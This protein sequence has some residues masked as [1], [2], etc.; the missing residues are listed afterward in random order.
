M[1]NDKEFRKQEGKKLKDAYWE[2][3]AAKIRAREAKPR[4]F[5][6]FVGGRKEQ[7]KKMEKRRK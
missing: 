3:H 2:K 5:K 1:K 7:S 4:S 6:I